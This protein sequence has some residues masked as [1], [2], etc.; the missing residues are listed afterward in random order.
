[1]SY[2]ICI[3]ECFVDVSIDTTTF[4]F[5]YDFFV[6]LFVCFKEQLPWRR[7]DIYLWE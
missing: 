7:E 1:M 3:Q 5:D 2:E 6:V 4:H